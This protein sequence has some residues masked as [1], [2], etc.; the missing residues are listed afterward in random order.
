MAQNQHTS[1][2]NKQRK[3][4]LMK[5]FATA[6]FVILFTQFAQA[7]SVKLKM[8]NGT[9]DVPDGGFLFY[10][11]GGDLLF[12]PVSNPT[13]ANEYN[14]T[15]WYQHNEEYTLTLRNPDG[16]GVRIEFE[17]ILINNDTL[18]FYEASNNSLIGTYCNNEYS[19]AFCS[20]DNKLIVESHGN[21]TVR[22]VSDYHWRDEGW[23]A[24]VYRTSTFTPR[25]PVAV[26]AA[27]DNQM[28]LIS[29]SRGTT[30]TML[31]YKIGS[32]D[33]QTYTEGSL[34]DLNDQTYSETSPL[35][36]TVKATI[37]GTGSAEKTF[38]F[39]QKIQNPSVPTYTPQYSANKI[40]TYFPAKPA[41]VNDTYYIRWT[42]N[43]NPTTANENPLLWDASGHEFQQPNNT[44]NTVPAGDIDY[45][46]VTLS[47]PF[48]V[49]FAVRGTTCPDR[50]SNV[51]T[52]AITARY[53]HMPTITF[54]TSGS[55][56]TATLACTLDGATIY[57]TT[58]G[59]DPDTEHVGGYFPTQQYSGSAF[60]VQPGTTVKAIAVKT[61]YSNSAV[62][63][64]VFVPGG[65]GQSIAN[66]TVVLLDDREDHSWSYYSDETSPI[67]SLNPADVKITYYGYGNS[68]M[69]STNTAATDLTNSDFNANVDASQVAVNAGSETENQFVYLKT[70]EKDGDSY[71]YTLIPNPFQKR[72]TYSSSKGEGNGEITETIETIENRATNTLIDENF[73]GTGFAI[74]DNT[75]D[76]RAWYTYNAGSGNN[77]ALEQNS[78]YAHSGAYSMMYEYNSS[79]AAN[80]YLVSQPF[81]VSASM[82]QLSVSLYE[83]VR[84]ATWAETFEVFFVKASDVTT[85]A[86]IASATHYGAIASASYNNENYAQ[87]SGSNT[88]SALKGQSV[89]VVV[90]CTSA[91]N[92]WQL[93]VD[94][95]TVTETTSSVSTYTI[96]YN[97]NGG[98][99]TMTD[100]NSPYTSGSSVTVL[101][102]SFTA[103]SGMTFNGWNT[104]SNGS[105]TS[106]AAGDH[107]NISANTTL[108]AQWAIACD[109]S[110]DFESVSGA[111]SGYN[112]AGS[113]P[114]GW[115]QIY[116]G[117]VN[118]TNVNAP[119]VHN[120]TSYP[121]LGSGTYI[122]S[123]YYLGFY[124][125]GNGSVCYA[126]M[127]A[128]PA[129][130][131]ANH[132][133]FK[134]RYESTSNGTLSYGV[135]DGTDAST[136][137]QI[138]TCS[139]SS[140]NGLVDVALS[141]SQ[142]AGK[143]IA[144]CWS[145]SGS[146]W[147]TAGIDD[148]CVSV[149]S[150]GSTTGDWRGF[151][152][153]RVKRMSSGLQIKV[154][155]TT[156]NSSQLSS[157]PPINA[158]TE[159]EF[160][161]SN[162][163]GN[164][165]DFEALWAKAW[166][167][168]STST[169]GLNAN[170]SYERNFM[171]LSSSP[172]S[173][174][175]NNDTQWPTTSSNTTTDGENL[176]IY[177]YSARYPYSLTQQIYTPAQVGGAG[178]ITGLAFYVSTTQNSNRSI[179]IYAHTTSET[180]IPND[181]SNYYT[182]SLSGGQVYSG[183]QNFNTTGW[184]TITL[185]NAINYNGT[186]NLLITVLDN[187][188]S[189]KSSVFRTYSS[190]GTRA[191]YFSNSSAVSVTSNHT[192]DGTS[193]YNNQIQF[194][195]PATTNSNISGL[196]VPLTI[197][198]YN[199]DGTG[200]SSSV[201][202]SGEIDCAADLK[203][204]NIAMNSVPAIIAQGNDLVF[205][206]GITGTV[207]YVYGNYL[208]STSADMTGVDFKLRLE[209]GTYD[210]VYALAVGSDTDNWVSI[211]GSP[212]V[213][214]T[215]GSDYDRAKSD[216]DKLDITDEF[217][218]GSSLSFSDQIGNTIIYDYVVKSGDILSGVTVGDGGTDRSFYLGSYR[219]SNQGGRRALIEGGLFKNIAGGY[220]SG[221]HPAATD[222]G[223]YLRVKGGEIAGSVYGAAAYAT[224]AGT[225]KFVF[226]GGTVNGW[227]AGG[228]N[229]TTTDGG[230]T[231]GDTYIYFGGEA[232]CTSNGSS[233]LINSSRGGNIFGAGSGIDGGETVGQ[234]NNSTIV[235]ADNAQV[236]RNVY[237]GGNY[238]YI[239]QG[240]GHKAEI[241]ILGGT[242]GGNVFGG[243]N[244][245]QGQIVNIW[246]MDGTITGNLYGGSNAKGI[247]NGLATINVSGG[248]V[249]NV[250]G[251]G[252][253][254]DTKMWSGTS[255][256]IN[257]GTI[258][259]N[260][261]GG[262]EEGSVRLDTHVRIGGGT[263]KNVF[264]AG[265]G[266]TGV[267]ANINGNTYVTVSGGTMDDVYGGGENGTVKPTEEEQTP[268]TYGFNSGI[269]DWTTI[270]ADGDGYNW[271]LTS[272]GRSG[273]GMWSA[274][275]INNVG[276]VTPDNYLISPQIRLE[277]TITF[278]ARA[279]DNTDYAEHFGLA[280]STTNNTNT[281][282]F[283]IIQE[284]TMEAKGATGSDG[285]KGTRAAGNWHQ[286]TVD[287]SSYNGQMGYVAIRHFNCTNMF[288]LVVDDI[289]FTRPNLPAPTD[290][291][292]T[293]TIQGGVVHGD[294]F[295]GGRLGKTTGNVI[296]NV[297]DGSVEGNVY[298][299]A[300]GKRR[301]VYIAGTHTVN[302]TGGNINQNVY[303]GSR[304]ADDAL[305]FDHTGYVLSEAINRVNISGGHIYYQVFAS[306]YFGETYGSVYAFIGANAINNAPNAA[307]TSGVS[308][309]AASLLIDGSVWAGADFGNFDGENF[310]AATIKGHSNVYIDGTG[311][312]T[313]STTTSDAGYMNIGGSVIGSGT[314]CFAGE[315]GS[316][317]IMRN[318]GHPVDNPDY[319]KTAVVEPYTTA[320]RNLMS[321]QFFK[322][323]DIDNAHLH[324]IG[325]GRINSL[326]STEEYSVYGVN[327]TLRMVNGSSLFIDFPMDQIMRLGSYTCSDVYAATSVSSYTIVGYS[328]LNSNHSNGNDNKFRVNNGS[329][330]NVKYLNGYG[331]HKDYGELIG[332]FYM[333]TD[334]ENNTCA[335][336]RPKQSTDQGNQIP[337]DCDNQYDGGFLSYDATKNTYSAAGGTV[338]SGVQMP[339]ENHTLS[340]K[341]GE[342]YFRIWRY[343][344]IFSYREGV[345]NAIAST[346][347]GYSTVDVV[348]SMPAQHGT[349]SYFRIQTE[350]GFP[351]ID[352]GDDVM[353]VN[354]GVYNSTNGT[355]DT[356]GW[357]SYDKT[358]T[359]HAFVEGQE[360]SDVSTALAPLTDNPNVNFGLVAIPQ[361]SLAGAYNGDTNDNWLIC[362]DASDAGEALTTARW[363]NTNNVTNPSVLFRLTYNNE[364][365]NNATWDPIIIIFEQCDSE[366][367][368]LDEI[369]V[370]LSV[371][372]VTTIDQDFG[373]Q[374][375]AMMN[376]TGTQADIY[377][378]KVVLPGFLPFVNDEGDLSNWT[379][380][381]A[382]FTPATGFTSAAWTSGSG[383]VNSSAPY[384]NDKFSMQIV[385]AANFDNTVGW[386]SYD[387]TVR[388]L[389]NIT[390]GTHLAYTDGRNP[391]AFDFILHYDGRATCNDQSLKLGELEVTL[392]FT[393]IDNG[394]TAHTQNLT[395]TIEVFR[396]G[397]GANYYLDGVNGDNFFDGCHPNSA[398]KTL[399]GIF[400][401]TE[402]TPGDNIFI[403]NTVTADGASALDWN[404]EQYGQVVLYRY[405]GGHTLNASTDPTKAYQDYSTDNPN[406]TGFTGTLVQVNRSMNMHGIILDGAYGIVTASTPDPLLVPDASKYLTPT[407]P[408]INISTNGILTV[409][410]ESKLQWNYTSSNGGAVYNAGKMIIRD[411]SDINHNAVLAENLKGAGVYVKD[412]ATLIVS[413]SITIDTNY[414][415]FDD[416]S[417][418]IV[419]KN[420]NVY[421]EG[422]NS[423]IQVGTVLQND[424][425]LALENHLTDGTGR[426][427]AKI[428]VTKGAWPDYYY[429]PIAYSDGGGS[430]YLGNLIP[431]DPDNTAAGD[432]IIYD[433]DL[434]YKVVTLNS[435]SPYEPSSDYL[436]WVGTW[437]TQVREM[438]TGFDPANIDSREDLA[439]AISYVNGLNNSPAHFNA[440]LNVTADIDMSANIWVPMGTESTP[441]TGTFNGNGH[442]IKGVKSSLNGNDMGMFANLNGTVEN[443]VLNVS[444]SGG[445]SIHMG[446]VA[447]HMVGG[448]ISN[449]EAA[450]TITGTSSTETIGGIVAKKT[451]GTIH[452]SFAVNTMT[453]TNTATHIGGLVGNNTGNLI[454]SY[455][456]ATMSGSDHIGGLVGKNNG[457]IENCYAVV[458]SQTFPAF[459]DE[460]AEG[461]EIMICYADN[462]NGYVRTTA[463]GTPT[464]KLQGHGTYGTVKNRKAIGYLYD[465]NKVTLVSG[466]AA[467]NSYVSDTI[468]YNTAGTQI[469]KW[470][471]ML[472]ALNQWV[473]GHTGYTPWFRPTSNL[474]N[475]DL[476]VLAFT[477][478]NCLGTLDA[479]GKFLRYGSTYNSAN[480]LDKLLYFYNENE[481][482]NNAAASLFLYGAATEVTRVPE[483]QVKVFVNEDAVLI[484]ADGAGDFINTT[485]GVTFDNSCKSAHDYFEND[486]DYDWHL[487]STPL[488]NAPIGASYSKKDGTTYVPDLTATPQYSSPVDISSL[489]NSY[490]PNELP[491]ASGY[492]DERIKW[493]FYSYF[494]PEYHWINLKRNKNN[495]FHYEY[496]R[497]PGGT[498]VYQEDADGNPHYQINYTGTDQAAS[499]ND[500]GKCVFTPGKGYMMAISQDSYM[501][502]TGT[503][504]KGDV[505]ITITKTVQDPNWEGFFDQGAN[506]IGN[507]YQAYL[508][509]EEIPTENSYTNFFVYIAETDQYKPY[510]IG[511]S[512]N[513]ETPSQYIHPHQ[514]F[515]VQNTD[516]GSETFTFTKDMATA[517]TQEHSFFRGDEHIDYPL[518]NLHLEN[519]EGAKNY[520]IIEVNRPEEGGAGKVDALNN[521]NFDLYTRYNQKDYKLFFTPAGVERVA[522]FFK[523][524]EDGIFTFT[525]NTQNGKFD[526]LKLIDNITGAEYDMLTHDS[527]T[528][529][530][531]ATD[532]AARF[533][534]AFN[535]PESEEPN[536]EEHD[537]FAYFNGSGWVIEGHGQLELIDMTG[538]VLNS[539]S[540]IGKQTTVYYNNYAAGTYLLRLVKNNKDIKTQK[541]VIY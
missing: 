278:W 249:T 383:Y 511:Q 237:G 434:Y 435:T 228:C 369:K 310:G 144:F 186:S 446:S 318:Y 132:I 253:G 26:V 439:W 332:F 305:T 432:Y 100:P 171:V 47:T 358:S 111:S 469:E 539:Q 91:A 165:I 78:T 181:G 256:N 244:Q 20:T 65:N 129:N 36:V 49:H 482:V 406:N 359:Q 166:V 496:D 371:S 80:C 276:A 184:H 81:N 232:Q 347:P 9:E 428:G 8:T 77:W 370:A 151:Y 267:D 95:I 56:G 447:A 252:Y 526:M 326:N 290:L 437:V 250:F 529:E 460:N 413:D 287:L 514:A 28:S 188:G 187:T 274:S 426:K 296:V 416:G 159:V 327:D 317:L 258:T 387:H 510:T 147:Y 282:A 103:P 420:S 299:G 240:D 399:S 452:S 385:P 75:Y 247:V 503:L 297:F 522:V 199:P 108:Y 79:N 374:A 37:D 363:Y 30:T 491:M 161:T 473:N 269:G 508:D 156:Y 50:F 463:S 239:A 229:G 139:N 104:A 472:S 223:V 272:N 209:T 532:F 401:R 321:L 519:A 33:Y 323:I 271:Q 164:E 115:D 263:M 138:G 461:G 421:L 110:E 66:G 291:M 391:T 226:T 268:I 335:Y 234:V 85:L 524:E 211:T 52:V 409:Y 180:S 22:F 46:N 208:T 368:V 106:Y 467:N 415:R 384:A 430:A 474:I 488:K 281:S 448:T 42:I 143:R 119:H 58:D 499:S 105:G 380:V 213:F 304:N 70:L 44:P 152:A 175:T 382:T 324:L 322:T 388:D 294:V 490:F 118:S 273:Y 411:G 195:R 14:W 540:I 235:I 101:S 189:T 11:S 145:Y 381:S 149:E 431:A 254:E 353:T 117:T 150:G 35:T 292:S 3:R 528:F 225:R 212:H 116:G 398:K 456:N 492:D 204:E 320:T 343:G 102:N 206:R 131:V 302:V 205:G 148:I 248:T 112:A 308:Y 220:E 481:E 356:Y 288:Y 162:A 458:G 279:Q 53:A 215:V 2:M 163:E 57:Y 377:T 298:G 155:G 137:V 68:T 185:D 501:S 260:V 261:Y 373:T 449:V 122:L 219:N 241:Y 505:D 280:V 154:N 227:I 203:F 198:T 404:G 352:Y 306:G 423:V 169:S 12:D 179:V 193:T 494:E 405:P 142:T 160:I 313:V 450:G 506:L 517:T 113:L 518:I 83:R 433:D 17:K 477:S 470:S 218:G 457:H 270:D 107:F 476:P 6:L 441:Y 4:S 255:V 319:S 40:T 54:A 135:I 493:D 293:V 378:A 251:G 348:I 535:A 27:C 76:S 379:F 351:M 230:E 403:V 222:K 504:N 407:A 538:R 94:D 537:H 410:A 533:Y 436:F 443:M 45:T 90:H 88:N 15:T 242:V 390:S 172:G 316:K 418:A 264:G 440:N 136:Y 309:N 295:G 464:P 354:A 408:M 331:D 397:K 73:D 24:K 157:I 43:S 395:I 48:Y 221:S 471:G 168:T 438:P 489:V 346:T 124:G 123:G 339:Y 109:Y 366:G 134:Y 453:A 425:I 289:S 127:P 41:G 62:A 445:T 417:K 459:A 512:K 177:Q 400:H 336:A 484:Q 207:E 238:G 444:F 51:V 98:T 480:G 146:S 350:N 360:V 233:T 285:L 224:A 541:I 92:E 84:S 231:D 364:L 67:K 63:S 392:N 451:A 96:T 427:S 210:N 259:N 315:M 355:P 498:S 120:G 361:G 13:N 521:A 191:A 266:A 34:V 342:Q 338:S 1:T 507:P 61:G 362:N 502:S 424:G 97:A 29:A 236:E 19:T 214:V 396:R 349:G 303:G 412:G 125:T 455:A 365:T 483:S 31:Q 60:T 333:M 74:Y 7:Q 487:M 479:D 89:R 196:T 277:G 174:S 389:K 170:A 192:P 429:N 386:S 525:W 69:T 265:K 93:Y 286:Y 402:Y 468:Y 202:I 300:F 183:T 178:T 419:Q 87:V 394:T 200:G 190:G 301:D 337:T 216:N 133:S 357:M 173:T 257:G 344:G 275:F 311:Y 182:F 334:D 367:N 520:A 330:L 245:Q 341:N 55:S 312:N 38:T 442:T 197:T 153:W 465:D 478:D 307:P 414:R 262:G 39:S 72:P 25:P 71:P 536:E 82:T 10:D 130:E 523:T 194:L 99:G 246:M 158:E 516:D 328:D 23:E 345:F 32:G 167:T 454:N 497:N 121:G 140:A 475:G 141:V 509:L 325:Q 500:D 531:K 126:I 329:Y 527:Y 86:A 485:V 217:C 64:D 283:T 128:L 393:N 534:I 372:T 16:G 243:S 466:Q 18:S 495:H 314:S 513:T 515:F 114:T 59:S 462:A 176:P 375:Y 340:N 422:E 486:L 284:W 376:G 530:G 5:A 21:M 201:N